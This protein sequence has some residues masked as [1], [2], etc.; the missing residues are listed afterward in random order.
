MMQEINNYET[1]VSDDASLAGTSSVR[2]GVADTQSARQ[3]PREITTGGCAE[4]IE[5][6]AVR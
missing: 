4:L 1:A 3:Q 2:D 6:T 5:Q